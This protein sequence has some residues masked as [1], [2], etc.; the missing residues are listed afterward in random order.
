ML[1]AAG[2]Q[3]SYKSNINGAGELA[4]WGAE[5]LRSWELESCWGVGEL[6]V[7]GVGERGWRAEDLGRIQNTILKYYTIL[8]H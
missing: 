6:G 2:E 5:K 1:E 4:G 3:R 8:S 7:R